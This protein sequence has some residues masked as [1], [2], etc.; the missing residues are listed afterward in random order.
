MVGGGGLL[1]FRSILNNLKKVCSWSKVV[2][3][4]GSFSRES[5]SKNLFKGFLRVGKLVL[6]FFFSDEVGPEA[7]ILM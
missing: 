2:F 3:N 1:F 7:D 5:N 4:L 6:S